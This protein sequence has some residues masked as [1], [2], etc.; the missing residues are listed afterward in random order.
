MQLKNSKRTIETVIEKEVNVIK[1]WQTALIWIGFAT[2]VF[3]FG[4]F[5][6]VL[7]FRTP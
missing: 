1:R 7:I 2:L 5:M 6:F 3:I 4:Q